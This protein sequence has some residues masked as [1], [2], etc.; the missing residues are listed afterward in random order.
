MFSMYE[1][2]SAVF[3]IFYFFNFIFILL[4]NCVES[5]Q[6]KPFS[7]DDFFLK[8]RKLKKVAIVANTLFSLVI[9]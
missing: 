3:C 7:E 9:S 6:Y 8:K 4:M 1:I 5:C 2:L